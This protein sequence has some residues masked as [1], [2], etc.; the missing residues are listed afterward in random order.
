MDLAFQCSSCL[1][2]FSAD[3]GS[4][5]ENNHKGAD[6]L[7]S[8]TALSTTTTRV[9]ISRPIVFIEMVGSRIG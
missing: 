9:P 5:R 7:E 6:G 3:F 8:H 2:D 4:I 1:A